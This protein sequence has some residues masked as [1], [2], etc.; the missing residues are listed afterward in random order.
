MGYPLIRKRR[1]SQRGGVKGGEKQ[2]ALRLPRHPTPPAT[3][4]ASDPPRQG[5]GDQGGRS[6]LSTIAATRP[7][8]PAASNMEPRA[9]SIVVFVAAK[10]P[11]H[12]RGSSMPPSRQS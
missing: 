8:R 4:V 10:L 1:S 11:A 9:T 3:G 12:P 2:Q 7:L 5:E 6:A